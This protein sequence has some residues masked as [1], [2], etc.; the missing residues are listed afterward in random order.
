MNKLVILGASG[1]GKVVADVAFKLGYREVVF[2]DDDTSLSECAGLSVVGCCEKAA[3]LVDGNT[4]FFVAIGNPSVRERVQESL[5]ALP[6]ATLVHPNATIGRRVEIGAGTVVMAGA[7]VNSDTIIGDGCI[8]NTGATVDHDN[9]IAD[10]AHIS[11][12]AHTAGTVG[13]GHGTWV[14]IGAVISNNVNVC[15]GCMIGAGAVVVRDIAISG[16]YVGV[17]AKL[18]HSA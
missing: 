9:R 13:V 16:T 17:P 5:K 2:L 10:Y 11:V 15:A 8:I 14:G 1:H 12:G 3:S 7:V 18:V 6:L 4:N